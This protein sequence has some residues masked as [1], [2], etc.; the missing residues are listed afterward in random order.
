MT[1]EER[2][3]RLDAFFGPDDDMVRALRDALG[4]LQQ[5]ERIMRKRRAERPEPGARS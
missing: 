1:I 4:Q 3:D 2:M 5:S